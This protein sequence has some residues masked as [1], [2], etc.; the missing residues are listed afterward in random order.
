M[1]GEGGR[2]GVGLRVLLGGT[3]YCLALAWAGVLPAWSSEPP[4]HESAV[5][6]DSIGLR[7][8]WTEAECV[9][10][11]KP[12]GDADGMADG[13]EAALAAAFAPLLLVD[14]DDC[15][16]D[17]SVSPA[18]LGGGYLYAVQRAGA[19]GRVRIAYLPAYHRDCGWKQ[20]VCL[21]TPWICGGHP[22]DSEI[23]VVEVTHDEATGRW[24]SERIFLSAHCRGR[25]DGRCR[26]YSGEELEGFRWVDGAR[27][28]APVV[29]VARGKHGAYPSRD[30]CDAGHWFYDSC[31]V[32]A[33]E[34]RFP[35]LSALQNLGSRTRPFPHG[36]GE[37]CVGPGEP[38]WRSDLVDP[39]AEECFWSEEAPFR[40]WQAGDGDG[41][42]P[43]GRYLREVAGF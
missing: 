36:A 42:T 12:D 35:V 1:T 19:A 28:G 33:A 20:P 16:W 39:D 34:V 43:Y 22:G 11:G 30:S 8:G 10:E 37:E 6:H 32:H 2:F 23:V 41:A 29:W 24:A 7:V 5:V 3:L 26:W 27:R 40:G 15:G 9:A 25:S 38:G 13:C 21:L 4:G 18:R 31:D 17:R 14:E